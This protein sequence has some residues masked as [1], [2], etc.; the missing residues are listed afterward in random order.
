MAIASG[1]V[2]V[3]GTLTN[4]TLSGGSLT[5]AVSVVGAMIWTSG[6]VYGS[7]TL[8]TNGL[9]VVGQGGALSLYGVLTNAGTIQVT[10]TGGFEL[11]NCGG[12]GGELVNL[13]GALVDIQTDA[14][15]YRVCGDEVF[16]NQ[17]T[18][19]K[20]GG[21]G[22]TAI[23]T[24]FNNTGTLDVES[25]TVGLSWAYSLTGGTLG[26]AISGPTNFAVINLS[27]NP[28]A[29]DGAFSA[30]LNGG[31][32]P[33]NNS[34]FQVLTF[35]SASGAFTNVAATAPPV[36]ETNLTATGMTL[37]TVSTMTWPAPAD[38]TYGAQLGTAQL[39]ASAGVP[40]TCVYNPSAGTVLQSG[41][42]QVLTLTFTPSNAAFLPAM[43]QVPINVLKA[44]LA[45]T[46][47]NSSKTYG[48]TLAFAGTE[49]TA[50]GLLNGDV[51]TNVTLTS[52]GAGA[53]AV[54]SGSPYNIVP[55][56]VEGLGLS[57]Y[58]ISYVSGELTVNPAPLTIT[59]NNGTK[60]YGQ[61][62]TFAGTEF[63]ATGLLNGDTAT[64]A[65][66]SSAGA[67]ATAGVAGSP[68]TIVPSGAVGTGLSNYTISYVNG[69][70]S[71]SPADLTI[72]AM[73][74]VKSY[75]QTEAF[76]GTE[77]SSSG[78]QNSET[79][80]SVTLAS[81][82]AAA[83]AAVAGSPYSIVPSG[84]A[85]GTFAPA[86][87]TINYADGALI[88][89][90]AALKITATN[91]SKTYG[92]TVTF[93]GTEFSSSGLQNSETVGSV[94]LA[95]AGAA[96]GAAV[97][98]SPYSIVPSGAAGGT[99]APANY[100]ISYASG[101]LTVNPA[102]LTITAN[103]GTKTYGQTLTFAGTE[104]AATGLL[105]GDTATSATLSSAGAAA[106]AGVGG[107]PYTIVPSAAVGTGLGNYTIVY[108][109]GAL[110]VNPA[111]LTITARNQ[112]KN[113]GQAVA[114]AGTE[115]TV[116]GLLNGDTAT[117]V[118]LSSAGAAASAA[119]SGSPYAIVPSAALGTGL[120]NYAITYTNGTLTVS[121]APL[122][123]A[124][125]SAT[126]AYGQA[127]PAFTGTISGIQNGD[128]IS[129]T[130]ACG[131]TASSAPAAYSIVP[132][133]VGPGNV[134][135]NYH[136][137][138]V[139]GTLTVLPAIPTV[140]WTN[141]APIVYGTPL[142]TNQ[143]NASAGVPGSLVYSPTNGAVL[144]VLTNTLSVAFAPTDSVDYSSLTSTVS[145]LVLPAPLAVTASNASRV[146]GQTNP[147]FTGTITGVVEGDGIT[148]V[149]S[150]S[151]NATSPPGPYMITANLVDPNDRLSNY[152]VTTNNGILT[153]VPASGP[154]VFQS[155]LLQRPNLLTFTWTASA[156]ESY[157]VQ[158]KTNLTQ[159]GWANLGAPLATTN[160]AATASDAV[161]PD[162][163]RFYRVV[164]LP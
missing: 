13:P 31:F 130:Y 76:A 154:P 138:I 49:F 15:I 94:T 132:T 89:N 139:N 63:A 161:G 51:A 159:A 106:T 149:F 77:F 78:L 141:P 36:W 121:P 4:L 64:S 146:Y 60:T 38:I 32:V 17:G 126:R 113:Y 42:E 82:G 85:G 83:G 128:N 16:I 34:S 93:A 23:N 6:N 8:G 158:Y 112:S 119:V 140:S 59:A 131:A 135:A 5:G 97:A 110:T 72:T 2:G 117:S 134:Q 20:S 148:A 30:N 103:N 44:P 160:S 147:V 145:L 101:A 46:A 87:Y 133:L 75:G 24:V 28:A 29:L 48:Q 43:M 1:T 11:H 88:V 47:G 162:Q 86:N 104:F 57:N 39:D 118:T 10:N 14:S 153:I 105:S 114:F 143:L 151:A 124:A 157:Q 70:L 62:L 102:P 152:A 69:A 125:N 164:L 22:T 84:A 18:V 50:T 155:I 137:T 100:A 129:A 81:A 54:V 120:A 25:G 99:F 71:V 136:V 79:V 108:A 90:P 95:S 74:E 45:I 61:T 26:V 96:A 122:M 40:G 19:R 92:Q 150:C 67:A 156:G 109:N 41:N 35:A 37:T 115:F 144:F 66:V 73:N 123:V 116:A 80:G 3:N 27:G 58:S 111:A 142:S 9:L 12:G 65:A 163:R 127:N 21:R 55:G 107:S 91:R 98:G 53:T 52:S 68:Y 7:L 56:A 33:T